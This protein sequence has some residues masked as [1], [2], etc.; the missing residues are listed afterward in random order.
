MNQLTP[1]RRR[2]RQEIM[3]VMTAKRGRPV[4]LGR[5]P[6]GVIVTNP[7]HWTPDPNKPRTAITNPKDRPICPGCECPDTCEDTNRCD[8]TS[9]LDCL[10]GWE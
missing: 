3:N 2:R 8:C 6:K 10:Y 7:A 5:P 1:E 4:R 9:H